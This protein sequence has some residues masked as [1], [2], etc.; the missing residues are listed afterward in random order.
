MPRR[1]SHLN[2][3]FC[4]LIGVSVLA[5]A[6]TGNT[7]ISTSERR[8]RLFETHTGEH[9]NIVYQHGD[10]VDASAL[11]ALDH[12]LRDH[13]TGDIHHYDPRLFDLLSDLTA[14]AGVP[15]VEIN[16]ICGYRSP[17]SNEYLRTHTPG[18][19]KNSLHMQAEAIDIRLPGVKTLELRKKALLLA[20]G[21]VGYYPASDFVHVDV[22][23][24]RQ[25]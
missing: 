20:R 25:W 10:T 8:L 7:G 22:G 13:R 19:S 21:G 3:L 12:F 14:S 5:G 2:R 18:V 9:L 23:R 4:L 17:W 16:V 6:N 15:D 1:S 24:V 11:A